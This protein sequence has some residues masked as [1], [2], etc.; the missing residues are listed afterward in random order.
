MQF[1][2]VAES[3]CICFFS[4]LGAFL[5]LSVFFLF[6]LV[7]LFCV[8]FFRSRSRYSLSAIRLVH[9]LG[10][11]CF[12]VASFFQGEG[13]CNS[14]L[15]NCQR[16]IGVRHW[17]GAYFILTKREQYQKLN[18]NTTTT[19]AAGRCLL[20]NSSMDM[21]IELGVAKIKTLVFG[22]SPPPFSF[23]TNCRKIEST[24]KYRH[25]SIQTTL[26]GARCSLLATS[27]HRAMVS[28]F[29]QQC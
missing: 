23:K 6:W 29:H 14:H 13:H 3:E 22:A 2:G 19:R 9:V 7:L 15:A 8:C 18:T 1:S 25:I 4:L 24:K 21:D 20:R 5:V 11:P 17:L 10:S 12:F 16:D 26:L 28:Y 27:Q